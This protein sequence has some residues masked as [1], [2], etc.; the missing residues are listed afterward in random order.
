MEGLHWHAAPCYVLHSLHSSSLGRGRSVPASLV[1][2]LKKTHTHKKN[3]RM[4]PAAAHLARLS[5]PL[6]HCPPPPPPLTSV[7]V[8]LAGPLITE[9]EPAT[10]AAVSSIMSQTSGDAWEHKGGGGGNYALTSC[11]LSL[12]AVCHLHSGTLENSPGVAGF[13]VWTNKSRNVGAL[14]LPKKFKIPY[15]SAG[16]T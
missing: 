16:G 10:G 8:I 9:P 6:W 4:L 2:L 7:T 15:E 5:L 3:P 11:P 12:A 14:V 13:N 1:L